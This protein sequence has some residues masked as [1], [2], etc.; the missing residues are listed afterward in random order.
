MGGSKRGG[1][2][3]PSKKGRVNGS[4]KR[5]GAASPSKKG[6]ADSNH[7]AIN[8]AED[9]TMAEQNAFG[10]TDEQDPDTSAQASAAESIAA[11]VVRDTADKN[12]KE[13]E[14]AK[15]EA[16][17]LAKQLEDTQRRCEE[18]SRSNAA[19][20]KSTEQVIIFLFYTTYA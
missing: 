20:G 17:R 11:N 2:A 13:A 8:E 12:R 10:G 9:D 14:H 18:L 3:S 5:G 4:G 7:D 19:A 6:R 16:Q 15:L 1:G